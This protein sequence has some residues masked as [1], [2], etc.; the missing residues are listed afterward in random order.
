MPSVEKVL[1]QGKGSRAPP[2]FAK[3][4]ERKVRG[5][6]IDGGDEPSVRVYADV[7]YALVV[8]FSDSEPGSACRGIVNHRTALTGLVLRSSGAKRFDASA[9][10]TYMA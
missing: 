2:P 8:R 10:C 1:A 3:D 9:A 6:C 4:V 5:R 7:A